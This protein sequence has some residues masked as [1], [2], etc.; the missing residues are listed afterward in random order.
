MSRDSRHGKPEARHA[1]LAK[2]ESPQRAGQCLSN[3]QQSTFGRLESARGEVMPAPPGNHPTA[4]E[5]GSHIH[6]HSSSHDRHTARELIEVAKVLRLMNERIDRL[7]W[8]MKNLRNVL[9]DE[10]RQKTNYF[11]WF[12]S[13]LGGIAV[14]CLLIAASRLVMSYF[15]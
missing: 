4:D 6:T 13:A 10:H 3:L 11:H 12:V 5:T 14:I 9:A 15:S 8:L 1:R 7:E 2:A